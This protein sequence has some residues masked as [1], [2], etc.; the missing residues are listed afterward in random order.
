MNDKAFLFSLIRLMAFLTYTESN[1][2]SLRLHHSPLLSDGRM[3]D[4]HLAVVNSVDQEN[5]QALR[6]TK[7]LA[8]IIARIND[9][10]TMILNTVEH[11]R[12][13][14]K[15]E[16]KLVGDSGPDG[17]AQLVLLGWKG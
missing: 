4:A 17:Q 11:G 5:V 7:A 12:F 8:S 14:L 1:V 9:G 3:R 2:Y 15:A 16:A 10:A 6:R 13:S